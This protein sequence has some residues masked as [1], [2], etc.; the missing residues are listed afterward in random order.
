MI[1]RNKAF[2]EFYLC[3]MKNQHGIDDL[4][5]DECL[6]LYKQASAF[7]ED[8][9]PLDP[10]AGN[11][12][13]QRMLMFRQMCA[14]NIFQDL[15]REDHLTE[16]EVIITGNMTKELDMV[17]VKIPVEKVLHKSQMK[18]NEIREAVQVFYVEK[19]LT[20]LH[21]NEHI[22]ELVICD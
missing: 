2:A 11:L 6:Q 15:N 8:M 18:M 9:G 5:Y 4:T 7:L 19:G 3:A 17:K 22:D 13:T 14:L 16:T 21:P 12:T 10:A 20:K 1:I